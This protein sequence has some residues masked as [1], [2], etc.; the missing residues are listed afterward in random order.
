MWERNRVRQRVSRNGRAACTRI[1]TGG[2][3]R[4]CSPMRLDGVFKGAA[5]V[6]DDPVLRSYP[7]RPTTRQLV[8]NHERGELLWRAP[9]GREPAIGKATSRPLLR[10]IE[11]PQ[12]TERLSAGCR[13][14]CH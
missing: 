13:K 10:G 2:P 9:S 8:Q 3:A 7:V 12:T 11:P 6:F 4:H 1:G 5:L 14:T